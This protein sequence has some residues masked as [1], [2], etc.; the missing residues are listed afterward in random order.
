MTHRHDGRFTTDSRAGQRARSHREDSCLCMAMCLI[1]RCLGDRC[2]GKGR[3]TSCIGRT[4]LT[5][6]PMPQRRRARSD[7]SGGSATHRSSSSLERARDAGMRSIVGQAPLSRFHSSQTVERNA[8]KGFRVHY[9]HRSGSS[10]LERA[11]DAGRRSI[12]G[13]TIKRN[14]CEDI[15]VDCTKDLGQE[16][17]TAWQWH[18]WSCT[19]RIRGSHA[20]SL[21]MNG[22]WQ[23]QSRGG[24]HRRAL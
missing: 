18:A 2:L 1:D 19:A 3:H 15:R 16:A 24:L 4:T 9:T 8:C 17:V 12:L 13:H 21:T 10:S 6:L 14:V 22:A 11:R 23:M 7:R 5:G 20:E